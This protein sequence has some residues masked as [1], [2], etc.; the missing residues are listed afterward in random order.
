MDG[1]LRNMTGVYI[2]SKDKMLLLYRIGSRI[3]APSWCCVGGH[4]EKDELNDA[5]AA[6][7]RELNE[8][9]GLTEA[10]LTNLSLRYVA[11][12][13]KNSELR[14][15]FYFFAELKEGIEINGKCEEGIL[16]WVPLE[17]V[18]SKEM[19]YSAQHVIK[20]YMDTGRLND[21]LYAA[22]ATRDGME[23]IPLNE[24]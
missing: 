10:D 11:M 1:K 18:N 19:P 7:L 12:R 13:L 23:F 21:Q 9:I 20:H 4:F 2:T 3:V 15:N 5:K 16:G 14:L 6:M 22:I 8:E 17:E 24:I